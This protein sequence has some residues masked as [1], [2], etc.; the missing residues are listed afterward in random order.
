MNYELCP[1][2]LAQVYFKL[3]PAEMETQKQKWSLHYAHANKQNKLHK[4]ENEQKTQQ[5]TRSKII[6]KKAEVYSEDQNITNCEQKLG[7]EF[8]QAIL[9]AGSPPQVPHLQLFWIQLLQLWQA[10]SLGPQ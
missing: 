2:K 5:C 7:E 9:R 10:R 3:K 4:F 6:T 8:R 1:M